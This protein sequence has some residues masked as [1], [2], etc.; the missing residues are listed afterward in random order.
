MTKRKLKIDMSDTKQ[1]RESER[2]YIPVT[3]YKN[4][5]NIGGK[6]LPENLDSTW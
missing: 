1:S 2:F 3:F 4:S 6:V 5:R